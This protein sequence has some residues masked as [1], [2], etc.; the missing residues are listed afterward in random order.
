MK[1]K[2]R[3]ISQKEQKKHNWKKWQQR[4]EELVNVYVPQVFLHFLV[5]PSVGNQII[6]CQQ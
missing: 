5:S 6:M 3:I 1:W 4:C 2:I